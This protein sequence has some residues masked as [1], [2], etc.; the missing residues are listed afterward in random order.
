MV[1]ILGGL[2]VLFTICAI[3]FIMDRS[4]KSD[5]LKGGRCSTCLQDGVCICDD[6]ITYR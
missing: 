1:W 4:S 2:L 5:C 3:G 6:D